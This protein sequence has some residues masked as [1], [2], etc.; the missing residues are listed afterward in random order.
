MKTLKIKRIDYVF[1]IEAGIVYNLVF[2]N[3]KYLYKLINYIKEANNDEIILYQDKLLDVGKESFFITDI[4]DLNLNTKKSLTAT[5]KNIENYYLGDEE[6][7]ILANINSNIITML[8]KISLSYDMK[9]EYNTNISFSD[10]FNMTSLKCSYNKESFVEDF[11]NYVKN[12]KIN[13]EIKILFVLNLFDFITSEE[14]KLIRKD[15][16]C[17]NICL[18]NISGHHKPFDVDKTIIIDEDLCQIC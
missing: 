13:N 6:K 14:Y 8:D 17:M 3:P 11:I 10:I 5:Y 4:F 18:F 7:I 1:R 9:L 15:L 2:E 12:I 16:E